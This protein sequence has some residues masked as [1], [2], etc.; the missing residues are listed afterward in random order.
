MIIKL[1]RHGESEANVA[2]PS[3]PAG[4]D[5]L[6]PLTPRGVEQARE[7][8]RALGSVFLKDCLVYT[9][10]FVRARQ[11]LAMMLEGA[12]LDPGAVTSREDP[13]LR[14][15]DHGYSDVPSQHEMVAIHGHFYYR[16]HGGESPAD[17]YDRVS[18]FLESFVRSARKT[19]RR[20]A[21]IV[22]HGLALRVFVMRMFHMTVEQFDSIA[23]PR[24]C[25]IVT[26][27]AKGMLKAPQFTTM[28]W[29]VEGLRSYAPPVRAAEG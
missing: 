20:K 17:C 28:R 4:A 8:G 23:N 24:N 18:G 2:D 13:R 3:H 21:L 11:T 29:G 26:V 25:D 15:V 22:T 10:P 14:E 16:Y 7:A 19:E 27:A 12:G 5:Y 9:S 1:V 6:V